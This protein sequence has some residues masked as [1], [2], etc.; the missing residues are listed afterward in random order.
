MKALYVLCLLV[1]VSVVFGTTTHHKVFVHDNCK[2]VNS[3]GQAFNLHLLASHYPELEY[4]DQQN[5]KSTVYFNPCGAAVTTSVCPANTSVCVVDTHLKG[6]SFGSVNSVQRADVALTTN[7]GRSGSVEFMFGAGELCNN[8]IARKSIVSYVCNMNL[9]DNAYSYPKVTATIE[10]CSVYLT[11]ETPF[12]CPVAN[13]CASIT[14]DEKC[15]QQSG[16][17]AWRYGKCRTNSGCFGGLTE[18]TAGII[19]FLV[20]ISIGFCL[21]CACGLCICAC[22][23]ARKS[24]PKKSAPKRKSTAGKKKRSASKPKSE[25]TFDSFAMPYQLIPGGAAPLNPYNNVQGFYITP[26]GDDNL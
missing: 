13:Y 21:I 15:N 8:G 22:K 14:S 20:V 2:Y 11:V 4:Y 7:N 26:N 10:E 9:A 24:C 12:A 6:V 3:H 19:S 16:I 25:D 18:T 1:L 17:C 23:V 5:T